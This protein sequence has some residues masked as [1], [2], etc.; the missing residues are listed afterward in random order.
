[1]FVFLRLLPL[2]L[3]RRP[4]PLTFLFIP[5]RY[6]FHSVGHFHEINGRWYTFLGSSITLYVW[7]L[8]R[9][10]SLLPRPF[11][12]YLRGTLNTHTT[13]Q[14]PSP[15]VKDTKT[16]RILGYSAEQVYPYPETPCLWLVYNCQPSVSLCDC[17]DP[18]VVY[19][20]YDTITTPPICPTYTTTTLKCTPMEILLVKPLWIVSV[21]TR[22]LWWNFQKRMSI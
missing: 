20:V 17:P 6:L 8:N 21:L 14:L 12:P 15:Q 5:L 10:I 4:S 11:S 18:T 3:P 16:G 22:S 1:M 13:P 2:S 9:V 7:S 19:D